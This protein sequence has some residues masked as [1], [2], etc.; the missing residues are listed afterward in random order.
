MSFDRLLCC[1]SRKIGTSTSILIDCKAWQYFYFLSA[2][3]MLYKNIRKSSTHA[4]NVTS[5][6]STSTNFAFIWHTMPD[7]QSTLVAVVTLNS[8][9]M[10]TFASICVKNTDKPLLLREVVVVKLWKR[11]HLATTVLSATSKLL[12][13]I[14]VVFL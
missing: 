13:G 9:V 2:G 7:E 6:S 10:L 3:C 5:H 14:L 11:S 4:Q 8:I 1:I 12:H